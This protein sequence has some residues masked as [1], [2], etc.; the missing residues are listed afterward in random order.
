MRKERHC[1]LSIAGFDPSGGAGVLA[2]I[3]TFEQHK[4]QGMGVVTGLTF[5]NDSE[6]DGVK[7]VETTEIEK[8]IEIL[9]RKFKFEFIKLGIELFER[10]AP[11]FKAVENFHH[12][13]HLSSVGYLAKRFPSCN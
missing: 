5:Q 13:P 9:C 7:W 1:V 3:K 6:F 10:K 4:V 12:K 2:D 8:Q 11:F